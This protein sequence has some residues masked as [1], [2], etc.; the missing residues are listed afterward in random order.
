MLILSWNPVFDLRLI[1]LH[2]AALLGRECK[3]Y[4]N[5]VWVYNIS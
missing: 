3:N 1:V 5:M 4:G 2:V